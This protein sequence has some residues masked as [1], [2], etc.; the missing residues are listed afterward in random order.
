MIQHDKTSGCAGS[1]TRPTFDCRPGLCPGVFSPMGA[2]SIR[3][4]LIL[5][6]AR[7]MPVA[8]SMMHTIIKS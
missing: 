8:R 7:M 5:T 2:V 3:R 6:E 4:F 1:Q